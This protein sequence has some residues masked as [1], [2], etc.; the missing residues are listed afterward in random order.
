MATVTL[1]FHQLQGAVS[2]YHNTPATSAPSKP[3]PHLT[4]HPLLQGELAKAGGA[5]PEH[6]RV[7]LP[8]GGPEG[9]LGAVLERSRQLCLSRY[10]VERFH[11]AAYLDL[12]RRSR[13]LHFGPEQLAVFAGAHE[14]SV[15]CVACCS[16]S[17]KYPPC[18]QVSAWSWGSCHG[19]ATEGS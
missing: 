11:E 3:E 8:A 12:Y 6:L 15:E 16:L 1:R 18:E 5:V 17:P 13:D 9:A 7:A 10:E 14:P 19:A 4:R 2:S